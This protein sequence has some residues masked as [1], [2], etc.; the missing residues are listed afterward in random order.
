MIE[1]VTLPNIHTN[2]QYGKTSESNKNNNN[3]ECRLKFPFQIKSVDA[4]INEHLLRDFTGTQIYLFEI[5]T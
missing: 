3:D 4:K 2:G 5:F 1:S